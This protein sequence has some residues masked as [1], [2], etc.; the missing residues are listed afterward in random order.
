[1][2]QLSKH[3]RKSAKRDEYRRRYQAYIS[4]PAWRAVREG[5]LHEYRLRNGH[6]PVCEVCAGEWK[7]TRDDLHHHTYDR[8]TA[9]IYEDLAPLCREDH[10]RVH[11]TIRRS[12]HWPRIRHVTASHKVIARL[13]LL[14]D[15]QPGQSAAG[16]RES[17]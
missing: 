15:Q 13:R 4:S 14:S 6:E 5:W 7:L 12:R 10:A 16:V 17:P 8:L 3:A 1:M 11:E 2:R 9:E